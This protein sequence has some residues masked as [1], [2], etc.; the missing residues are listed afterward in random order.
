MPAKPPK[1]AT[2]DTELQAVL[3]LAKNVG[4]E[5]ASTASGFI[6]GPWREYAVAVG[7]S[8]PAHVNRANRA[9]RAIR[10]VGR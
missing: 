6:F 2:A 9:I 7:Q 10:G 3:D 5:A 8:A 1:I 4:E